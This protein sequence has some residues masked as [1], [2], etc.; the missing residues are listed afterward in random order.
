[1]FTENKLNPNLFRNLS[2]F[3]AGN[4]FVVQNTKDLGQRGRESG[5]FC[6]GISFVSLGLMSKWKEA[7]VT[8]LHIPI[9]A[10]LQM[11][12]ASEGCGVRCFV[13]I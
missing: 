9:T 12:K 7:E 8:S 5:Y 4:G 1:M 13:K 11:L 6:K 10:S 2:C 3:N